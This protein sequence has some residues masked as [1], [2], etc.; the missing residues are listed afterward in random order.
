MSVRVR[1]VADLDTAAVDA[2]LGR[3]GVERVA[4]AEGARIPGSYWGESEAGLEGNRLY[5]RSDTPVHSLLHEL[6]HF[7]CMS[8]ERRAALARDAGGDDAEEAAVCYLQVLLADCLPGFGRD[9]SFVD[10]D[11]WGYSFREGA[12]R[13]WFAG[14]GED[15]RRW[16]GSHGL[17]DS[18]Q[19]P[20]WRLRR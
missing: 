11:A 13:A 15:A 17:I 12:A 18:A 2:L 6:A 20:T 8:A 7:V 4:V 19:H 16:L 14:D 9:R 5:L 3:F 10:M 1:R